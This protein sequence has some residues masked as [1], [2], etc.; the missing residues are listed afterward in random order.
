MRMAKIL[1]PN[2]PA[3]PQELKVFLTSKDINA[4]KF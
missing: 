3:T 4:V 2:L 1:L